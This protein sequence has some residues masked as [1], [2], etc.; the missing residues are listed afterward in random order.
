[1]AACE[2][3]P[4]AHLCLCLL[5]QSPLT[6]ACSAVTPLHV[7]ASAVASP[8][9]VSLHAT[10]RAQVCWPCLTWQELRGHMAARHDLGM[11]V[12]AMGASFLPG[13]AHLTVLCARPLPPVAGWGRVPPQ[14]RRPH[15]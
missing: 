7:P 15:R 12:T 11:L 2:N 8:P 13:R 1:M 14:V 3:A 4:R 9:K 5:S 10:A 6:C